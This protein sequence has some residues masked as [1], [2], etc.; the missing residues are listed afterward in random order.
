MKKGAASGSA[1]NRWADHYTTKAKKENYPARS[2]YKLMEIQKKF[3]VLGKGARVL[4]LG[5]APGSWLLHA[6][7]LVGPE[8]RVVGIDLKPL[9]LVLPPNAVAL[10]GDIFEMNSEAVAEVGGVFDA[11]LSDMAPATTGRKDVDALR[12]QELCSAALSRARDLLVQGGNFVCQIFQG[13]GFTQFERDVKAVF[14]Q[15]SIFKPES[16]RKASKEI[17]IIGMGKK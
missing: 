9:E 15:C 6:A 17:Y 12:S 1:R 2:V 8:G 4:D 14:G 3:K 16:C 11:V 10:V 13:G 7:A 5:C